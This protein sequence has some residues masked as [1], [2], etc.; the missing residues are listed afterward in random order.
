MLPLRPCLEYIWPPVLALQS[1]AA[2]SGMDC[3]AGARLGLIAKLPPNA[4]W[5]QLT[6]WAASRKHLH[7]WRKRLTSTCQLLSVEPG[8]VTLHMDVRP[9][10]TTLVVQSGDPGGQIPT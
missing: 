6:V 5:L 2:Q 8:C 3:E 4:S 7:G 1:Y 9:R 10:Q